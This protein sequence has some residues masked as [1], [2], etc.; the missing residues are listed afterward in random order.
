MV[1][2]RDRRLKPSD[3]DNGRN[4]QRSYQGGWVA[5][6]RFSVNHLYSLSE[7]IVEVTRQSACIARPSTCL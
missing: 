3:F 6:L 4:L 5:S 1:A 2:V 7:T